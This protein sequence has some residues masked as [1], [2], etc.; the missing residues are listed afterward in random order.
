M[1]NSIRRKN[2]FNASTVT[3]GLIP[4]ENSGANQ[5]IHLHCQT[6]D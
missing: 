4:V 2:F 6:V 1:P 5:T 3:F